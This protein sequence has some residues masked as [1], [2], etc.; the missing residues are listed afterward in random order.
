MRWVQRIHHQLAKALLYAIPTAIMCWLAYTAILRHSIFGSGFDLAAHSQF[1]WLMSHHGLLEPSTLLSC[2]SPDFYVSPLADHL[3]LV[4][5]PLAIIYRLIPSPSTL[6]V[7]QV[8][9]A[10]LFIIGVAHTICKRIGNQLARIAALSALSLYPPLHFQIRNDFHTDAFI[11]LAI[12]WLWLGVAEQRHWLF[13]LSLLLALSSK[14]TG[15]LTMLAFGA[16][17]LATR[18]YRKFG[19]WMCIISAAWL[20][21]SQMLLAMLRGGRLQ[22][23]MLWYYGYLGSSPMEIIFNMLRHPS[24]PLKLL[25]SKDAL[26]STIQMLSPLL[27]LPLISPLFFAPSLLPLVQA[28]ISTWQPTRNIVYQ[29]MMQCSGLLILGCV[30]AMAFIIN[31]IEKRQ[32]DSNRWEARNISEFGIACGLLFGALLSWQLIFPKQLYLKREVRLQNTERVQAI[33]EALS[34]IPTDV[35]VIASTH[36]LPHLANRRFAWLFEWHNP[37]R[38]E[39]FELTPKWRGKMPP[40]EVYIAIELTPLDVW[41]PITP[42]QLD[43]MKR[44]RE[45]KIL[46]ENKHIVLLRYCPH[47]ERSK[48]DAHM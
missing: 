4:L 16:A 35:P 31:L 37:L 30:E 2:A 38:D 43:E 20:F 3:S 28:F 47:S 8:L 7:I 13:F 22:P 24:K 45:I 41:K 12:P 26:L 42:Q 29:V 17:L 33:R 44:W 34:L 32:R 36:L 19:M 9:C 39:R 11:M 21:A 10:W 6:I 5:M 1:C 25:L 27:F 18:Q 15:A 46:I 48:G 23:A 14:E 40:M